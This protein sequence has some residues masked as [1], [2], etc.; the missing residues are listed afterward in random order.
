LDTKK[1]IQF[2]GSMNILQLNNRVAEGLMVKF[3]KYDFKDV[4]K[5]LNTKIIIVTYAANGASFYYRNSFGDIK[6]IHLRPE[7]I[8]TVIDS[9]GAGDAFLSGFLKIYAQYYNQQFLSSDFFEKAFEAGWSMAKKAIQKV[10]SR[11][12]LKDHSLTQM[13]F[14]VQD[15]QYSQQIL[16]TVFQPPSSISH[17]SKSVELLPKRKCQFCGL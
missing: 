9:T 3:G 1:I 10:G 16:D 17:F 7:K 5:Q 8:D 6:K 13:D 4:Y 15:E 11:G 2:F 12:H 14:S